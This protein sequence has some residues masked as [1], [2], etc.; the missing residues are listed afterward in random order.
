MLLPQPSSETISNLPPKYLDNG[1]NLVTEIQTVCSHTLRKYNSLEGQCQYEDAWFASLENQEPPV[2]V[3][4]A[5]CLF[6]HRRWLVDLVHCD[7]QYEERPAWS[8]RALQHSAHEKMRR[9]LQDSIPS[10]QDIGA[11]RLVESRWETDISR[12]ESK[13][14]LIGYANGDF[15]SA[16]D[17]RYLNR[18][19]YIF[20]CMLFICRP[21]WLF[22]CQ[23]SFWR[24]RCWWMKSWR[25]SIIQR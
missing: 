22:R 4:F 12:W 16:S 13:Q 24:Q 25:F 17:D 14:T 1:Q 6:V 18:R 21:H 5:S 15:V 2:L 23:I 7:S 3:P 9:G 8:L 19:Q 11:L 10:C 20:G